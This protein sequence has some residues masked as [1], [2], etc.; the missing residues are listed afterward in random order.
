M[1]GT[2]VTY[3]GAQVLD[4]CDCLKLLSIYFILCVDA[5]NVVCQKLGLLCTDPHAVGC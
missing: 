2:L 5:T 4:A 1:L 3:K